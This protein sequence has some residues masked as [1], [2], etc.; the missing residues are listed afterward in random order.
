[1]DKMKDNPDNYVCT[2]CSQTFTRKPSAKRHS[3]NNH[4]GRAPFVRSIDYIIGRIEG[5][6]QPSDPLLYRR[7][8]NNLR[9]INNSSFSLE[10]SKNANAANN[11]SASHFTAIPDKTIKEPNYGV[12]NIKSNYKEDREASSNILNRIESL[13]GIEG[14]DKNSSSFGVFNTEFLERSLK[15]QEFTTLVN[16]YHHEDTAREILACANLFISQGKPDFVEIDEK[17]SFLRKV[18]R[19]LS[20]PP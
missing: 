11:D 19:I 5:R 13:D 18:D 1:M 15:W 9:P 10:N 16:R 7:K 8:K 3:N 2:V 14:Y 4:S 20:G 12:T 6:Y 17:L